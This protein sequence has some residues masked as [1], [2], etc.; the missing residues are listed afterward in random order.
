MYRFI[1][2]GVTITLGE[3]NFLL[4]PKFQITIRL[5]LC[6]KDPGVPGIPESR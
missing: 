6:K 5:S 3:N 1:Q 4:Y 2:N